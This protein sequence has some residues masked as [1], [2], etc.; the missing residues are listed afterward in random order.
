MSKSNDSAVAGKRGDMVRSDCYFEIEK[1]NSGGIKINLQSKV[2]VMYGESIKKQILDMCKFFDI[3][4]A[5]I[6]MEDSGALP[7]TIA[8]RFEMAVKKAPT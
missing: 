4:N 6:L 8:A 5:E 1:K 3:K 2:E 7:F